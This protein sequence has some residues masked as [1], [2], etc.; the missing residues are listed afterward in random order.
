MVHVH[1]GCGLIGMAHQAGS[2][3]AGGNDHWDGGSG[4]VN[5]IDIP[6]GVVALT[7][8]VQ[9]GLQ[10]IGPV[11]GMMAVGARLAVGLAE[12]GH[13]IDIRCMVFEAA[14]LAVVM[15]REVTEV[16]VDTLAGA[17]GGRADTGAGS[18]CMTG[19]A[20]KLR[21][22]LAATSERRGCGAVTDHAIGGLRGLGDIGLNRCRMAVAVGVEVG[23]MA[24]GAG[25][26]CAAIDRGVAMAVNPGAAR[27][28]SRIVAGGAGGVD[29]GYPVAKVA[30]N[31][32]G[33]GQH[34]GR[35]VVFVVVKVL[36]VTFAARMA[37]AWVLGQD[38]SR[39]RVVDCKIKCRGCGMAV[40]A[41]VLV[42][43]CRT[44]GEMAECYAGRVVENDVKPCS[45]MHD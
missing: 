13:R 31:A 37:I 17:S 10:D 38:I 3:G 27:A 28:V 5:R 11:V 26:A 20:A 43:R 36:G 6:C 45:R 14:G 15:A 18:R 42:D 29:R 30:S 19:R 44:I 4:R 40:G 39:I 1:G 24:L 25:A 33:G 16:A 34:R 22:D 9:V 32:G 7:A 41:L 8:I 35:M 12:V 21:M 2:L 23:G